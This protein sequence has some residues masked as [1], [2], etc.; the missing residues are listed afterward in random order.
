MI[1]DC[2]SYESTKKSLSEM[3]HTTERALLSVLVSVDNDGEIAYGTLEENVY[4]SVCHTLGEPYDK[5]EVLWF[6]GTRVEDENSFYQ[7]GILTKGKV[8]EKL[9]ARL[10]SLCSGLEQS[11]SNPFR[12]SMSG[13]A[14]INDEGPFAFLIKD[15]AIKAPGANHNYT[16]APEMV[17]DIA[18]GL[19]GKNYSLLVD[20][21][22][23]VTSPFIV[24]FT[25]EPKGGEVSRALLYLKLIED[26]ESEIEAGSAA[27][28]FFNSH[29]EA[30]SADRI[31]NIEKV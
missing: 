2:S 15:V 7:H 10:V 30:I 16:E 29:G 20:R 28:K 9:Q 4:S 27:N 5:M 18:G 26:G 17:Q 14:C 1:L 31:R 22:K 21:F 12:L 25:S 8:R 23:E 13:K 3:F 24:S 11:G 19:L 6:H